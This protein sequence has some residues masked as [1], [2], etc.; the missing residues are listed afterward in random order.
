MHWLWF[1][2]PAAIGTYLVFR[3]KSGVQL[4][5][6]KVF[7]GGTAK[8][9][10]AMSPSKRKTAKKRAAKKTTERKAGQDHGARLAGKK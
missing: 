2:L 6:S 9:A 10:D 4:T 3:K 5:P 7:D 8:E 1:T